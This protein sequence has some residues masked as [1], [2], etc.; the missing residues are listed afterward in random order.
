[1]SEIVGELRHT[2]KQSA[3][4]SRTIPAQK[5]T[6]QVSGAPP[7]ASTE[8]V[9][10]GTPSAV[11]KKIKWI[12]PAVAG[13]VVALAALTFLVFSGGRPTLNP[14]MTF[15]VLQLPHSEIEYPGLS[16]DGN[17]VAYPASDA[18]GKWDVY[19]MNASVGEPRR[20]TT[21]SCFNIGFVDVSP[22][23][24]QI[25]YERSDRQGEHRGIYVVSSLGGMS[26]KVAH[27]GG[28]PRWRPD[29]LRI[30]FL[31]SGTTSQYPSES[32]DFELWSVQPDG[33]DER[34]ELIDTVG[35]GWT[36]ISYA[37]SPDASSFA[38]LRTFP[39]G[40]Q[41]VVI[42]NLTSGQ[43]RQLTSDGTSID[44]VFWLSNDQVVF[45]SNRT[46][47]TNIWMVSSSG[48]EPVQITKGSGPDL[49]IKASADARTL[50]YLQQQNVGNIWIAGLDGT[51]LKQVTFDERHRL[52]PSFSPDGK[53]IAYVMAD[54]DPLTRARYLYVSDRFGGERRQLTSTDELLSNPRWSPDGKWISYTARPVGGT[55]DSSRTYLLDAANPGVPRMIG[56]GWAPEW[57]SADTIV[58]AHASKSWY[59]TP[60]GSEQTPISPDSFYAYPLRKTNQTLIWNW[61]F[62]K[63]GWWLA[64]GLP[65]DPGVFENP[66]RLPI[67][68]VP[69]RLSADEKYFYCVRGAGELWRYSFTEKREEIVPGTYPGIGS[70]FML[71][72]DG[73]EIIYTD[74]RLS[75]KL[76]MVENLFE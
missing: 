60:D 48:G 76:V 54:S 25:T 17:W 10:P 23:G 39:E 66:E 22:D 9:S 24:G 51:G 33:R 32:G 14:D 41:E 11:G 18:N 38:W 36:R 71:S 67:P 13:A 34:R 15:R 6:S 65:S 73:R 1:M 52:T 47:N 46:G 56:K 44:E 7:E 50:L 31:R 8:P 72:N 58:A 61:R 49:G 2:K 63:L 3:R 42:R 59:L 21:D 70:S 30:A 68:I 19:Y 28:S 53:R 37:W 20:V 27:G 75:A 57:L 43:E 5:P 64:S 29:G 55:R 12:F 40:N 4:V 69:S 62:D 35:T 45:S 16:P 26:R 74:E